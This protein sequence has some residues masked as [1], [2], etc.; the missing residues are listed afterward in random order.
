MAYGPGQHRPW[1]PNGH[2]WYQQLLSYNARPPHQGFNP[3]AL[4]DRLDTNH[5]N[6]LSF[7]EFSQG[8]KHLLHAVLPGPGPQWAR[9]L[10]R[11]GGQGFGLPAKDKSE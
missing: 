2:N 1:Q 8:I 11:F 6:Q 9:P 7:E 5:D 10:G 4:F 3:K